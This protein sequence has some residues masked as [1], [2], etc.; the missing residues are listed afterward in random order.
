MAWIVGDGDGGTVGKPVGRT[1]HEAVEGEL[2]IEIHRGVGFVLGLVAFEFL[3]SEDDQ[4]GVGGEYLLQRV[5]NVFRVAA[6]DHVP[7]EIGGR[8]Q[9][10]VV[11]C[12]LHHLG[13]VKPGGYGHSTH[14]LF[15]MT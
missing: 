3:V 15:H 10:Q 11:F 12:Q 14:A 4:L 6:A 7:A 2:G 1:Y 13:V 5:L 9:N 8:V